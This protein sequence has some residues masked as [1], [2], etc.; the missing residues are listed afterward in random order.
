[1]YIT[2]LCNLNAVMKIAEYISRYEDVYEK[3]LTKLDWK[4]LVALTEDGLKYTEYLT[5][6]ESNLK[7]KNIDLMVNKK[8]TREP[9]REKQFESFKTVSHLSVITIASYNAN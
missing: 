9:S 6:M 2:F 3:L 7:K 8:F 5:V 1:M 4:R